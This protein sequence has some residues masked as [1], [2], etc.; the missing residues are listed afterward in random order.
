MAREIPIRRQ[1]LELLVT[2]APF[3]AFTTLVAA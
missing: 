2:V 3:A 1:T